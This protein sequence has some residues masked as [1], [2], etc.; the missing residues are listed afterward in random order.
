[1]VIDPL[2]ECARLMQG[3]GAE[4][5]AQG[6]SAEGWQGRQVKNEIWYRQV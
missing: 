1:M 6:G 5:I 4:V 2:S 3:G